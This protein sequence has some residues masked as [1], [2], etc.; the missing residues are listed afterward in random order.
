MS[1]DQLNRAN[2]QLKRLKSLGMLKRVSPLA[3]AQ[4]DPL[5]P[6]KAINAFCYECM[7]GDGE[8]NAKVHVRNCT[9]PK[10]LL[11]QLRPWQQK[12]GGGV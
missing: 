5:S 3:K 8:P 6:R 12:K 7:G 10:C 11:F 9:A 2:A 4:A 1:Q